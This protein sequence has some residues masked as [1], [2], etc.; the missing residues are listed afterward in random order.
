LDLR[1][2]LSSS[3]TSDVEEELESEKGRKCER[4]R[5]VEARRK[6]DASRIERTKAQPTP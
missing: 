1:I 3:E 2:L 6:D 5:S 4:R